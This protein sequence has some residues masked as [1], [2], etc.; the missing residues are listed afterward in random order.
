MRIARVFSSIDTHTGGGPTRTI[1]GGL[2]CIPGMTI[3]EK[4]TYLRENM[5]RVRK[6]L[7]FE[8]RGRNFKR[9]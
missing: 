8:P 1:I 7:M 6:A 2:P 4:T 3:V 9:C 5:D